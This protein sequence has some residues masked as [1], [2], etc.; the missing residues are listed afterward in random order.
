VSVEV[1]Q[2][3]GEPVD[4]ARLAKLCRFTLDRLRVHP[5]AELCL[6]LVDE[7]TIAELN[8]RWM[9]TEGPT[10][11]L[12]WPMDEL[13]PGR[14]NEEPQE[15]TL[16][17][18][19]ICPAIARRQA[20]EAGAKGQPGYGLTDELDLLTVHGILHLLGYDHA[21]PDDHAE[22]FGLQARLLAE[23]QAARLGIEVDP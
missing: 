21:E 23:W 4:A 17:D 14:V 19:A 12:A 10:D 7:E 15:G 1:L 20:E 5:L 9:G 6:S 2:E 16:G 3:S 11:V 22:M 13:G 18:I 8:T